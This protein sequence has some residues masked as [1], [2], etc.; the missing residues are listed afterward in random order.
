LST[1]V[2][3][4]F[5]LKLFGQPYPRLHEETEETNAITVTMAMNCLILLFI[6]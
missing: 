3:T 5:A 4:T 2:V 1:T 6:I